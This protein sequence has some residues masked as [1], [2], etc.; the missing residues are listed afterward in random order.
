MKVFLSAFLLLAA[1]GANAGCPEKHSRADTFME[2]VVPEGAPRPA[3]ASAF[4]VVND[5]MTIAMLFASVGPPDASDGTTTTIYV[6]CLPDGSEVRVG[7]RDGTTIDYVRHDR[8]EL[9]KRRKKK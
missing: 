9:Y 2:L 7:S 3:E 4:N 6:Y 5:D 8:K 1:A